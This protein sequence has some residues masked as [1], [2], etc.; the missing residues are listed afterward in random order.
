MDISKEIYRTCQKPVTIKVYNGITNIYEDR[1]VPC[2]K[3]YHCKITKINEW[4]TRMVVQSNY[5]K[6][7]YFG[8]LTYNGKSVTVY[9]GECLS[10]MSR[11]NKNKSLNDTPIILRKDHL[12]KFF[13]RLRKNTG[14]KFSYAACGEYGST[15]SRPH[16]H[17]IIWSNQPISKLSVYKAWSTSSVKDISKRCVIG[18]VEHRDIKNN[19]DPSYKN[20]DGT[21]AYKYVCK[22]IQKYDF[23]FD[24]L[25]NF[26]QHK[27]NYYENFNYVPKTNGEKIYLSKRLDDYLL[28]KNIGDFDDYKKVFSPFFVCSKKPAIGYAYLQENINRFQDGDFRLFGLP[29]DYIFPLYFIRKTKE[30]ICPLKAQSEVNSGLTSYSRLPK[31]AALI[32]NIETAIR[33]GDDT[34][35]IVQLFT[36]NGTDFTLE[37][38]DRIID[39]RF[40]YDPADRNRKISVHNLFSREYLGFTNIETKVTYSFRFNN[41]EQMQDVVE[42]TDPYFAMYD[43]KGNYIGNESLEN[44]KQLILYYYEQLK[45]K[46]LLPLLEKSKISASAKEREI[47]QEYGTIENYQNARKLCVQ[48]FNNHIKEKQKKYKLTKTFE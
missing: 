1:Q 19:P 24:E 10:I 20:P 41:Y 36:Y 33:I 12:Q 30:H 8:T 25:S 35:Q 27:K 23:K 37:S 42:S 17:Y 13:K 39:G 6:Y 4:V 5:Y 16:F 43:R 26:N 22:Y 21:Y 32:N 47:L 3:C 7:V 11:F 28:S 34:N 44:V 18:K 14:V 15:Y 9:N 48:Q 29:K 38:E 46:V 40:L 2:G 45:R 31:M